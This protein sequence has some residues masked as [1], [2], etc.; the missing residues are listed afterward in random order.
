MLVFIA[1]EF[2]WGEFGEIVVVVEGL[3]G[4]CVRADGEVRGALD[5]IHFY[6]N[7]CFSTTFSPPIHVHPRTGSPPL[8]PQPLLSFFFP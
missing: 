1:C 2:S 8:P 6:S 5:N 3:V 7:F 4:G